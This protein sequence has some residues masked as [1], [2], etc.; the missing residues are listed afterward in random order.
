[1]APADRDRGSLEYVL[2]EDCSSGRRPLGRQECKVRESCVGRFYAHVGARNEE[3][4]GVSARCR[5]IF[6]LGE[7]NRSIHRGR[8]MPCLSTH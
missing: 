4:F 1:M 8:V 3:S 7:G 6:L 2:R 5:D